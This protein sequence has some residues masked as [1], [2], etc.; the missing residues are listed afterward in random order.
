MNDAANIAPGATSTNVADF[1]TFWQAW[2]EI[3]ELYM[4]NPSTTAQQKMYGAITGMVNSLND[5]YTEFFS[6]EDG[7]QFQQNITGN[8]GGIGAE[9]GTNLQNDIVIIAPIKGTPAE[10]AGLKPRDI[11]LSINGTSTSAMNIDDAVNLIR[12]S[13][14]FQ[15]DA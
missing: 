6:P 8:F 10:T 4:R 14:G 7:R 15:G 1:S 5:P 11:I 9:L 3:N 13:G 12:R 2:Q